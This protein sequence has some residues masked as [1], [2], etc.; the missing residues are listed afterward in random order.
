MKNEIY[1][2]NEKPH[3]K[4]QSGVSVEKLA[5]DRHMVTTDGVWPFNVDRRRLQCGW[6]CSGGELQIID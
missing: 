6:I 1:S 3:T 4:T 5:Y 2:S